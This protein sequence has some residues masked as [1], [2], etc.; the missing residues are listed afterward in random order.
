MLIP[1]L[2]RVSSLSRGDVEVAPGLPPEEVRRLALNWRIIVLS[3]E[4][5]GKL[6]A[7]LEKTTEEIAR[8][9]KELGELGEDKDLPENIVFLQSRRY[10][11]DQLLP[12]R[13]EL[14]RISD[15]SLVLDERG[16]DYLGIG[17]VFT[18]A[19]KEGNPVKGILLGP[20]EASFMDP[21]FFDV[22]CIVSYHSPL[23]SRIWGLSINGD[24]VEVT[25]VTSEKK[26]VTLTI[27]RT[28]PEQ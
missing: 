21:S 28:K 11:E 20:I 12:R 5:A 9:S 10:L 13:E 17:S 6:E 15:S 1:E 14:Q 16:A 23:G 7:T 18:F 25:Y 3:K 4:G 24:A 22:E 26:E 19:P 27:K 2:V 8:V